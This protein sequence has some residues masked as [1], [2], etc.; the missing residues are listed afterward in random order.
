MYTH[1]DIQSWAFISHSIS[2]LAILNSKKVFISFHTNGGLI[3]LDKFDKFS[4]IIFILIID[5]MTG[6]LRIVLH[7]H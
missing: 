5:Y 1:N 4:Y 7:C 3:F 6:I 2:N